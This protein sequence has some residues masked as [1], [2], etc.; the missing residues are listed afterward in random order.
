MAK[1]IGINR[2]IVLVISTLLTLFGVYVLMGGISLESMS[3]WLPAFLVITGALTLP[4]KHSGTGNTQKTT[5]GIVSI[6]LVCIG[7][8]L[9]LR[10]MGVVTVP[11]LRYAIGW[12]TVAIGA[13]GLIISIMAINKPSKS[14]HAE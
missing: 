13:Y 4:V 2:Y 14:E 10:D 5:S 6:T 1:P 3:W 8:F 12:G 11:V 7:A 9:L